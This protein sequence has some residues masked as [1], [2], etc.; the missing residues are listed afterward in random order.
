M[1]RGPLRGP[2]RGPVRGP[3]L[4]HPT[5]APPAQSI[6]DQ[7]T[8]ADLNTYLQ[9]LLGSSADFTPSALWPASTSVLGTDTFVEVVSG[10]DLVTA[11]G[12]TVA[13]PHGV[14][15][16][17]VRPPGIGT[18]DYWQVAGAAAL[19][20]TTE[21]TATLGHGTFTAPSGTSAFVEK[22]FGAN[23]HWSGRLTAA[24]HPQVDTKQFGGGSTTAEVMTDVTGPDYLWIVPAGRTS[25]DQLAWTAIDGGVASAAFPATKNVSNVNPFGLSFGNQGGVSC[26]IEWL[27]MWIGAPAESIWTY[28]AALLAA[29][30]AAE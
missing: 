2:L 30:E 7:L 29:L 22:G 23:S 4:A 19:N 10:F 24:G 25:V 9:N 13:S 28:Q 16:R 15:A 5:A 20:T 18:G 12:T 8:A 27:A 26:D 11:T 17:Q 21:A 6:Y 14:A 1:S 3:R